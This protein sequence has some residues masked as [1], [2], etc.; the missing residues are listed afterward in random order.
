MPVRC[1]QVILDSNESKAKMIQD[2]AQIRNERGEDQN[3]YAGIGPGQMPSIS[4]RNGVKTIKYKVTSEMWDPRQGKSIPTPE[5]ILRKIRRVLDLWQSVSEAGLKFEYDGFAGPG[6]SSHVE[7]PKD[8]KL[9]FVLNGSQKYG[10]MFSGSGGYSGKIPAGYEKGY[11]FINTKAGLYTLSLKTLVHETGHALGITRHAADCGTV[12]HCG[13]PAWGDLEFFTLSEHDRTNFV[14]LWNR[15]KMPAISGK[16]ITKKSK[17]M[18]V[19][20][21]NVVNGRAFFAETDMKGNYLIPILQPGR[22]KVFAKAN[23]ASVFGNATAQ[24]PSWY[25]SA[26]ASTN[27]PGKAEEFDVSNREIKNVDI[28]V[29]DKPSPFNFWWSS[30]LYDYKERDFARRVPSFLRPGHSVSFQLD[31]NEK[32]ISSVETFGSAPDYVVVGFDRNKNMISV[33]AK[34]N[35]QPGHRLFLARDKSDFIQAGVVGVHIIGN[36]LPGFV[37]GKVEDQFANN[38]DF[39][40]FDVEYW[41]K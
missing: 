28:V 17:F 41:K 40:Q 1:F 25:I 15:N 38:L 26:S 37:P 23:E 6:Y 18:Y 21:V 20:A 11:V 39:N 9:Y 10:N 4:G 35:A 16:V 31:F 8:G 2:D 5:V 33:Q 12:M 34:N 7:L 29:I 32:K 14:Y 30:A 27:D 22:Y 13:T 36:Q 24:W 19:Y 3:R